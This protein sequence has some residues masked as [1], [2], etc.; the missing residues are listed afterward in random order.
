M[1]LALEEENEGI[2]I[3]GRRLN[4]LIYAD[5]TVN[6]ADSLEGI[7]RFISRVAHIFRVYGHMNIKKRLKIG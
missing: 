5:D 7:Q 6:I 3:N 1:N 4:N 2:L